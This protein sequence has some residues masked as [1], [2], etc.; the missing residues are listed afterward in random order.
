MERWSKNTL[1]I[2]TASVYYFLRG[3][4]TS[5]YLIDSVDMAASFIVV[6]HH[7]VVSREINPW[8]SF[9]LLMGSLGVRP[10]PP[11]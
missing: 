4:L 5:P 10:N 3:F 7:N 2:V 1:K 6:I 11:F 9:D 8:K